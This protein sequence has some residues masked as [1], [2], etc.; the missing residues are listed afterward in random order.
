MVQ[1]GATPSRGWYR[2][3]QMRSDEIKSDSNKG[4][5]IDRVYLRSMGA[6]GLPTGP[7]YEITL[8]STGSANLENV[9]EKIRNTLKRVGVPD[10][11][12]LFRVYPREGKRFLRLL[13]QTSGMGRYVSRKSSLQ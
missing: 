3:E 2:M 13:L 8:S 5:G 7:E 10:K 12:H 4:H 11:T 9:P 1:L 6:D